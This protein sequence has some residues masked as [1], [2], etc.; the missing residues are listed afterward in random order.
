[1]ADVSPELFFNSSNEDREAI[2][3]LISARIRCRFC[4]PLSEERTPMLVY[5]TATFHGIHEIKEF[6]RIWLNGGFG[7]RQK[8]EMEA[9][10]RAS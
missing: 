7:G 4:G 5:D 10:H 6:I 8:A 2:R 9:S 3:A 1:M